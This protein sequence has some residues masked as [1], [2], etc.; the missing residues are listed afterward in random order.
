MKSFLE[1]LTRRQI[2]GIAGLAFAF[3]FLT[4]QTGYT[5]D[6]RPGRGVASL[7]A[8]IGVPSGA[9]MPFAGTTAPP[10]WQMAFGQSV[11]TSAYP[12]LFA[13]IGYTYGGSGANFNLPDL[14]G[15]AV[16]GKD[17]MGG[18]AANRITNGVSGITAT[19]L[20]AV[21]GDQN[22]QSHTHTMTLGGSDGS[23]L[24]AG[25]AFFA[26]SGGVPGN[27][28]GTSAATGTGASGNV[29]PALIANYII[30]N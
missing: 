4:A 15:R 11:S 14:R 22:M 19:T 2:V 17:N 1:R 13:A 18:S 21:G 9:L 3:L 29:P 7:Q 10:G 20:G 16:F 23:G 27:S 25:T 12:T 24:A 8:Q 5:P 6:G 30:K 28:T 26:L